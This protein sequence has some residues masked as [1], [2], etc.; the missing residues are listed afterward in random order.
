MAMADKLDDMVRE[1]VDSRTSVEGISD[2]E[3]VAMAERIGHFTK[4]DY[5]DSYGDKWYGLT[6]R[7]GSTITFAQ[8]DFVL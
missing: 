8:D 1:A 6:F 4:R 3:I 2:S 7:D 5:T